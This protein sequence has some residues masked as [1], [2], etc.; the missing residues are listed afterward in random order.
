M[1]LLSDENLFMKNS[2]KFKEIF[3]AY[4]GQFYV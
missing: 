2:K 1:F 4:K 3:E